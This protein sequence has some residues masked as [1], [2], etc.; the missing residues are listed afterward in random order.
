MAEIE[1][2]TVENTR[3]AGKKADRQRLSWLIR[4]ADLD[5]R[6]QV[7]VLWAGE[8]RLWHS[9]AARYQSRSGGGYEHWLAETICTET[10]DRPLPGTVYFVARLVCQNRD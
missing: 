4:V 1:L 8:D 7:E 10:P 3:I 6:K 2:L 5:Y 9:V